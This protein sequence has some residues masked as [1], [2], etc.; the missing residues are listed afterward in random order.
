MKGVAG[1]GRRKKDRITVWMQGEIEGGKE[2][3]R[4]RQ[5]KKVEGRH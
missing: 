2:K 1:Q 3:M 5:E 4:K